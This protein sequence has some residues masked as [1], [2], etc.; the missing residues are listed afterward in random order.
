MDIKKKFLV[1][2]FF[3]YL[4]SKNIFHSENLR[5]IIN[6]LKNGKFQNKVEIMKNLLKAAGIVLDDCL[7]NLICEVFDIN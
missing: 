1:E 5:S 6:I 4:K 3:Y 7:L 2:D